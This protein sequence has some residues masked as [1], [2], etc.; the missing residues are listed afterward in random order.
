MRDT[1][2]ARN[3]AEALIALARKAN[4]LDAYG[5]AIGGLADA[6]AGDQR[7]QNFLASPSVSSADKKRVIEQAFSARL[8][9]PLVRFVQ[10]LIDNRRQ[11]LLADVAT[12]YAN[13]VDEQEGRVHARVTVARATGDAERA[14]IAAQL[15]ARLGKTVVPHVTVNPQILG[16]VIVKVGDTVMDGSV[17]RRLAT[18]RG[19]LSA[20][21]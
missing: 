8:P 3:Y 10:K 11:L 2:I 18:L 5:A 19:R 12:E 16:G 4:A 17:R 9:R 1:T 15:S 7:L 20:A 21:R 14:A 6:V 13:L